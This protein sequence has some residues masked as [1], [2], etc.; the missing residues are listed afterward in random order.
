MYK[1]FET[2]RT[3]TYTQHC[4]FLLRILRKSLEKYFTSTF[5]ALFAGGGGVVGGGTMFLFVLPA[6]STYLALL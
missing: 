4:S 2:R 3:S 6:R 5:D 1:H